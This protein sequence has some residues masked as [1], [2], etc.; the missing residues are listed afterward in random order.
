[1]TYAFALV[2]IVLQVALASPAGAVSEAECEAWLCLPGGFGPAECAP[3][4]RAVDRRLRLRLDPLPP[5]ASCAALYNASPANL[6]FDNQY[7]RPGCGRASGRGRVWVRVDGKREGRQYAYTRTEPIRPCPPPPPRPPVI[8]NPEIPPPPEIAQVPPPPEITQIPDP[9][10]PPPPEKIP[11]PIP[12]PPEQPPPPP[13]FHDPGIHGS[14]GA[15][16]VGAGGLGGGVGGGG[17]F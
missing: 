15:G 6:T 14:G 5:W 8:P 13:P 10:I 4:K 11:D 7:R 2:A 3:A 16:G 12:P 9:E 17:I 1:M